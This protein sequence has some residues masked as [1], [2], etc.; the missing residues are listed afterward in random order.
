MVGNKTN[1]DIFFFS[2]VAKMSWML[3]CEVLKEYL[4]YSTPERK[5]INEKKNISFK[6]ASFKKKIINRNTAD[7][8][9]SFLEAL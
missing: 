1:F 2:F 7:V 6:V 4:C 5:K 9:C 8:Q 3:F